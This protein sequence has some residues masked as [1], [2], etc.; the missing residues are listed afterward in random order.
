MREIQLSDTE[1]DAR[2][3]LW[4]Q[5]AE[6]PIKTGDFVSIS[7]LSPKKFQMTTYLH[8]TPHSTIDMTSPSTDQ[9]TLTIVA[10]NHDG[11]TKYT[12]VSDEGE[13]YIVQETVLQKLFPNTQNM[14][15]AFIQVIPFKCSAQ[16]EGLTIKD[17]A[18]D[19]KSEA[20]FD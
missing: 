10:Y 12:L 3:S 8:T 1:G 2:V 7:H 11:D 18:L 15:E 19:I 6:S 13:E 14:Q 17:M 5:K 9:K 4:G 20:N 16:I